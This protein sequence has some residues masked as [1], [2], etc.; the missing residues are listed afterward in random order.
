MKLEQILHGSLQL[1]G[2]AQGGSITGNEGTCT[3]PNII[4]QVSR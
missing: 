4:F 3:T 1:T 2:F